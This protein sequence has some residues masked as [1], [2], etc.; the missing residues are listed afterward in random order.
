VNTQN[1]Q[2]PNSSNGTILMKLSDFVHYGMYLM[3]IFICLNKIINL[4]IRI[5]SELQFVFK[6][7]DLPN[8]YYQKNASPQNDKMQLVLGFAGASH[9]CI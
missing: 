2:F 7:V 8:I 5:F 4:N 1:V 6:A 3:F 9:N